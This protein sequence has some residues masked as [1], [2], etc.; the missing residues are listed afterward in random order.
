MRILTRHFSVI[1]L[2]KETTSVTS[3]DTLR[4]EIWTLSFGFSYWQMKLNAGNGNLF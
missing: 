4:V 3:K 2:D 1:L